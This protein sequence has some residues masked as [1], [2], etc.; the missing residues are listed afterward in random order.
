MVYTVNTGVMYISVCVIKCMCS[1]VRQRDVGRLLIQEDDG[2]SKDDV[3]VGLI[4]YDSHSWSPPRNHW[5][6]E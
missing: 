1:C 2:L 6:R 4:L 3:A 5:K